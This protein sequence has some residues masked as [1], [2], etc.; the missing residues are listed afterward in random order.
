MMR[1]GMGYDVHRLVAG[2]PLTLG[3]IRIEHSHGLEGH[4]DADVL[5]HAM[6]DALLGAAGLPDIGHQFPPGDERYRGA[7]SLHLMAAVQRL[8]RQEGWTVANLD[9]TL[10][11]EAPR[12][13]PYLASMKQ[14]I[15]AALGLS[16][17]K[18]GIK[19]TTNEGMGF[20]GRREGIAAL[21]VA[22]IER[23]EVADR[24]GNLGSKD[25]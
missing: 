5:V 17:A 21:A 3:G 1:V 12:V 23:A 15:G 8:L 13:A 16:E 14:A 11:A 25:L 20:V 24:E 9:S 7:S 4:S 2:I 19:A 22:L 18:I 6:M 10:V